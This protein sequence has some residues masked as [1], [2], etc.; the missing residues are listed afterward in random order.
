MTEY[1][2]GRPREILSSGRSC[3]GKTLKG[4]YLSAPYSVDGRDE[5]EKQHSTKHTVV[6]VW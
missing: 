4:W 2:L 5:N 3:E 1:R 6:P